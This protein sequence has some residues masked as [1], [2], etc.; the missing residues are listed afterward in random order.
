MNRAFVDDRKEKIEEELN[1]RLVKHFGTRLGIN[2]VEDLKN[3]RYKISLNYNRVFHI[4]DDSQKKLYVRN[5]FFENIYSLEVATPDDLAIPIKDINKMIDDQFV[6]LR[7]D[8][9][10][11]V[12]A[13]KAIIMKILQNVHPT[14][15]FL[16]KFYTLLS[17]L[18]HLD[19]ISKQKIDAYLK[20][21][22]KY[23]KY[24]DLIVSSGLAEHKDGGLKASSVFKKIMDSHKRQPQ[25]AVQ[26]AISKIIKDHYE[27]II[28]ELQLPNI[29]AYV[30]VISSIYYLKNRL[31]INSISITELYRVHSRLFDGTSTIKFE[32]RVNALV[33]SG[34]F[35]RLN[36]TVCLAEM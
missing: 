16:N 27:Y 13:N 36:D 14:S 23:K 35:S 34:V 26:E 24:I 19:V 5:I 1:Y 28:Y 7:E 31:D 8:L 33:N 30:N 6:G 10:Q 21:D 2:K 15:A 12:V 9:F 17:E 20:E 22:K 29:K 11:T 3:K 4:I 25:I 18:L 32:E